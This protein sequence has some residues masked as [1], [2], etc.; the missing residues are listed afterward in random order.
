MANYLAPQFKGIHLEEENKLSITKDEI[1]VMVAKVSLD[2]I[3]P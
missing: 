1:E 2:H 3:E